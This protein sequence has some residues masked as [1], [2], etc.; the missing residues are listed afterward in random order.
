MMVILGSTIMVRD[1]GS[2]STKSFKLGAKKEQHESIADT[3]NKDAMATI[4][5]S[6]KGST[7][8]FKDVCYTVQA[9]GKP[10]KLLVSRLY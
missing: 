10:K 9:D 2:A 1:N 4:G 8:T 3:D 6:T 7:F 5:D